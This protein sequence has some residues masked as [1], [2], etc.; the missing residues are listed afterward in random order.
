MILNYSKHISWQVI[1]DIVFIINEPTK[2]NYSLNGASKE[3][4]LLINGNIDLT[5]MYEELQTKY[6]VPKNIIEEDFSETIS[7]LL[8]EGLLIYKE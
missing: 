1:G 8:S 6:S 5:E 4:W 7:Y 2:E 3:F